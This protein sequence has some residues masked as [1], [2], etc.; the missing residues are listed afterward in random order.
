MSV[1]LLRGV[2]VGYRRGSNTQYP[3]QVYVL[4]DVDSRLIYSLVGC[5]VRAIDTKGNTYVGKVVKVIGSRNPKLIV[6]FKRS[7]PG[8]LIGKQ[9]LIEKPVEPLNN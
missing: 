9:V 4:A 2:I 6:H 5:K 1:N 3:N 8:Q 7:I